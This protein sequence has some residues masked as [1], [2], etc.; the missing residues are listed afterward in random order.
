M[1]I[2]IVCR[3]GRKLSFP[4]SAGGSKVSC[5]HCGATLTLPTPEEDSALFRWYCPCGQRLKAS[6]SAA[7]RIFPCP[8]CGREQIV[9]APSEEEVP[10][11]VEQPGESEKPIAKLS[12]APEETPL[13]LHEAPEEPEEPI[14][15]LHEAPEEPEEEVFS[16]VGYEVDIAT[17]CPTCAAELPPNAV[18]CVAC[19]TNIMTG[20]KV[21]PTAGPAALEEEEEEEREGLVAT[22]L[23]KYFNANTGFQAAIAGVYQ[24]IHGK[25]LYLPY[26]GMAALI[27]ITA[28]MMFSKWEGEPALLIIGSLLWGAASVFI[29]AGF[30]GCIKDSIFQRSFGIERMFY[31]S[32]VNFPVVLGACIVAFPGELAVWFLGFKAIGGVAGLETSWSLRAIAVMGLF[33]VTVVAV[34]IAALVPTIALLERIDPIRALM[35]TVSFGSKNFFKIVVLS[36]VIVVVMAMALLVLFMVQFLLGIFGMVMPI[37]LLYV[38]NMLL[39]G[40]M[41]AAV[42]GSM[43][44]GI[45]FLYLSMVGSHERLERIRRGIRGP[46]ADPMKLYIGTGVILAAAIAAASF[47]SRMDIRREPLERLT[48]ALRRGREEADTTDRGSKGLYFEPVVHEDGRLVQLTS[49]GVP[50]RQPSWSPDGAQIAYA[51]FEDRHAIYTVSAE[52]GKPVRLLRNITVLMPKAAMQ[53]HFRKPTWS[54]DGEFIICEGVLQIPNNIKRTLLKVRIED[55]DR[56]PIPLSLVEFGFPAWSPDGKT[57]AIQ[58]REFQEDPITIWTLSLRTDSGASKVA[59]GW[60]MEPCWS[61]DGRYIAFVKAAQDPATSEAT[62]IAVLDRQPDRPGTEAVRV[63]TSHAGLDTYPTW[64]P[65][66]KWIAFVSDS[67]GNKDI[68]AIPASGGGAVQLTTDGAVDADPSW[69]PDGKRIAFSS[70]RA[71]NPAIWILSVEDVLPKN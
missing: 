1:G 42:S 4:D 36:V 22:D 71:G 33:V 44:A 64:S 70:A 58:G 19:G 46:S 55:E 66:G 13:E 27:T 18:I 62:Q 6:R 8:R 47:E 26:A 57:L 16:L 65:D 31:H 15:E 30:V 37:W 38:L 39:Q 17:K 56:T 69:S 59:R 32:A 24:V 43:I 25:H 28:N 5:P 14:V 7:G 10:D 40:C 53:E 52:G 2:G 45:M 23:T 12:E 3:C 41:A 35:R 51:R 48:A 67:S 21:A 49:G 68:W 61:P 60:G 63:L 50:E 11:K 34:Q 54:P 20:E 9:P 29:L